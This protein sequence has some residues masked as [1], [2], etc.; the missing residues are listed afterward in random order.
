M[1][2]GGLFIAVALV[3]LSLI[4]GIAADAGGPKAPSFE[5]SSLS[6]KKFSE[7]DLAGKATLVI[8]WA[9]WCGTCQMELPKA[10]ALQARMKG[11]PFQV[12]A[13]GFKDEE[14][15][16]R[17]YVRSHPEV[18]SFPVLYDPGDRVAGRFGARFTPTLFLLDK[19]GELVGSRSG[20]G[21]F[22]DPQFMEVLQRLIKEA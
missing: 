10:H 19:K 15:N 13:I 16:I 14:A 20:P 17:A 5:L 3:A 12:V 18:F 6:G 7:G 22:E 1:K 9:S 11:K 21:L 4:G 8:F 2:K